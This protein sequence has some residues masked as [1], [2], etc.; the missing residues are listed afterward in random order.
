MRRFKDHNFKISEFDLGPNKIT[1]I[2]VIKI[3]LCTNI[4]MSG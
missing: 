1:E 4:E 3:F 2:F